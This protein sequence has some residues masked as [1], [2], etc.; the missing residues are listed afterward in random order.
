MHEDYLQRIW[1]QSRIPSPN[2]QLTDGTPLTV[3]FPGKHNQSLSGPDF[4][5]ACIRF[6]QLDFHGAIEIHVNGSDWYKHKHHE[7]DAYNSVILHVVYNN[8]QQVV[9]NGIELPTLE[10][11]AFIDQEHFEKSLNMELSDGNLPCRTAINELDPIFLASM[12]TKALIQKLSKKIEF[13]SQLDDDEIAYQLIAA[14]FGM[15]INKP[16]FIELAN[17]LP[18]SLLKN[19]EPMKRIHLILVTSG[20]A[21]GDFSRKIGQEYQWHFKGTRPGNFPTI[22]IP[23]FARFIAHIDLKKLIRIA[24]SE[25]AMVEFNRYCNHLCAQTEGLKLSNSMMEL[26]VVN[27]LAPLLWWKSERLRNEI[28]LEKAIELL[29]TL[30]SEKNGIVR[31][32]KANGVHA[33]NAFDSQGLI[34]LNRYYCSLKKCLSCEVGLKILNRE[35]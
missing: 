33:K 15:G 9:Q 17:A 23:Q 25:R 1:S 8:D 19:V 35:M 28:Y 2:L 11:K 18:W 34:A 22:R 30:P 5:D 31:S 13:N 10:L 12:K 21:Q 14:T 29:E 24:E 3:K 32:W 16:A 6:E 20:C 26:L 4:Y 27:V 7:D